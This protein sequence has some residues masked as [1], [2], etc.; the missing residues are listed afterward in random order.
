MKIKSLLAYLICLNRKKSIKIMK[1]T[2]FLSFFCVFQLLAISSGAQNAV[3][4]IESQTISVGELIREI[5]KQTDYLVVFSHREIDTDKTVEVKSESGK[6]SE[7]LNK[8]FENT[9][10][11]YIFENDYIVLTTNTS[12]KVVQQT[13]LITG[14]VR[15][16]N[17]DPVVGASIVIVGTNNATMTDIDGRF[18][19][20]YVSGTAF[21]VSIIGYLGQEIPIGNNTRFD[22]TLQ[23]D[24]KILDEVVVVGYGT[25]KKSDVNAS[26]VSVKA[27]D[28]VKAS[29]PDFS[30][31]LMGRAAGLTVRQVSAQPG[32]G[33]EILI[34]GGASTGAG[35][36]PLYVVDGF[37]IVNDG[38]APGSGNQWNSGNHSPLSDINPNDIASIEILKDASATAIYGA[39][40][41]NGVVLIT[42]KRG[43][44]KTKVEY[45]MSTS[46]QSIINKPQL[47]NGHEFMVEQDRYFKEQYLMKNSIYPYGNAD[48]SSVSPYIPKYSETE[49]AAAGAGTNWYDMITRTG[50]VN[51]HNLTITYGNDDLRSLVSLNFFDQDGVIK[52]SSYQRYSLR[53]NLDH[54]IA[55]WWDYGI[56]SMASMTKE[57]NAT[58]GGGRDAT[59]GIIESAL[60]YSPL[61]K[62][63]RDPQTG[64]WIEDPNQALLNHPLSYMD[65]K[66]KTKTKRFLTSLFTNFHII[67]N[68]LWVKLSAGVDIRDGLRQNY[69]PT[70]T[71]YGSAIGGDANINSAYREDYMADAVVNFQK[72]FNKH[73]LLTLAGYS[74]QV[75]ND[76]GAYARAMGFTSDALS[77]YKLQAGEKRPVVSS[78]KNKHV[79][80]SYFGRLQ[81]SFDDKY[82]FTFTGRVDGSDRFGK[83]NRYAF[84]PSGAF[85]WRAIQED[86]M[87]DF[88]WLSDAKLRLSVGQVGNENL[89]NDAASEYYAFDGRN[90]YFG[91][92]EKRGVNL[93]KFGNPNLKWETTTEINFGLDYGFFRNRINGSVDV[94]Y[95]EIKDLL[96]WRSLPHTSVVS[97]VMSNVGKTRSTGLEITLNTINLEGPAYWESS[98]TYTSHRDKWVERDPKVIL[99][100]YE[101]PKG[102]ITAV[103]ALIPDGIKQP[104][105]DTPWMPGLQPGQQKYKD[106]NGLDENGNLTGKPDGKIDQADVVYVGTYAPKFT[107]G[108]NNTVKYKGFDLNCFLYASIGAY[109]WPSTQ[110]EHGVYGGYGTQMLRDNYNYLRDIQNRWTSDNMNTDMPSGEVSSYDGYGLPNWQKA[111]Y[112][113]LKSLTLGY[114]ITSLFKTSKLNARIYLTGQNLFTITGYKGFDPE[115]ENDRA[116]YPQQRTFSLGFDLKF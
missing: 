77:Y 74:Y 60:T 67:K 101:D 95:K 114:D 78:Y 31:M 70:T 16:E 86:F 41:A 83:N 32:G 4:K 112:L 64:A 34:R 50:K 91:D 28:L 80:A 59:A 51:Q 84:F 63:E 97:S 8:A 13:K 105:E 30:E 36:Q 3:I 10:M 90:Y 99:K 20:S 108:L 73:K 7:F 65:I 11:R 76:E 27:D 47:L 53:Y 1:I 103:Y 15:D 45:S 26:I 92:S 109:R 72:T 33:I 71:R 43:T 61:T 57:D 115:V 25:M 81:Y 29:S 107:M 104:G 14:T 75:Q 82:L 39:R 5:E 49:M 37:P 17:G 116:A 69:Y 9:N 56:S 23:E 18:S 6:V 55:S 102:P 62:P 19:L 38:V 79:L 46:V 85:A 54:K 40:G 2:L 111:S 44:T 106:V 93:N 35:N 110:V 52:T 113:R 89:G 12:N 42:T 94:F 58:L 96:S 22:I 21:K 66:D 88:N 24:V 68:E 48:P 100:P 87:K 98:F